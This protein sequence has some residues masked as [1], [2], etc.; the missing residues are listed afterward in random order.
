MHIEASYSVKDDRFTIEQIPDSQLLIEISD[1]FLHFSIADSQNRIVWLEDFP[2][3]PQSKL[4]RIQQLFSDHPLLSVRFWKKIK[5]LL[6][7]SKKCFVPADINEEQASQILQT[8]FKSKFESVLISKTKEGSFAFEAEEE[9]TTFLQEFYPEREPEIVLA[10]SELEENTL[11]FHQFGL[12]LFL[13]NRGM[14]SYYASSY[15]N[16]IPI[17]KEK[18]IQNFKVIGEVTAYALEFKQLAAQFSSVAL[19]DK[20]PGL[21][22]SQYFQE[23]PIHRYYLLFAAAKPK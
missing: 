11:I 22:F 16:T 1:S 8:L 10:E 17:L 5:V 14:N 12:S 13:F 4:K 2:L 7:S 9:L 6:H 18:E 21:T 3:Y 23:C 20:V 19:A 15:A